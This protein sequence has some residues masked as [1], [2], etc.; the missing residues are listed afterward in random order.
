LLSHFFKVESYDVKWHEFRTFKNFSRDKGDQC[1]TNILDSRVR[2][3]NFE[4]E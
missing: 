3:R 2:T 1:R 4:A